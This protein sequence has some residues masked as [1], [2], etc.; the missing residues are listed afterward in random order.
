MARQVRASALLEDAAERSRLGVR[1]RLE[2]LRATAPTVVQAAAAT[3]LAWGVARELVGH[4]TPFF[5]P[6][7]ALIT[8]GLTLGERGRRGLEVAFGVALGIAVADLLVLA[9]GSGTWQ[10]VVV[11]GLAMVVAILLGGSPTLVTQAAASAVLV[12]VLQPPGD[13]LS[14]ARSVDAVVGAGTALLVSFV[15]LPAD[16]LSI[17]RRAAE[18]VLRELAASLD[19]VAAALDLRSADDA[20]A[21]LLRA[22][23]ID[24]YTQAFHVAA[25]DGREAA[26]AL[27]RR[28][29]RGSVAVYAVAAGQLDLAVHNVRVLAR[30][31][32][33]AIER[34]ERIPPTVMAA[35]RELAVAVRALGGAL[36]EPERL[37]GARAPA[38]HAAAVATLALEETANLSASVIVGQVRATAVDLL[39]GTGLSREEALGLVRE[40]VARGRDD[41]T[42]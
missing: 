25:H 32:L 28:G 10:L 20:V 31:A 12:V 5:A 24:V 39:R 6:I 23:G 37:P 27:S 14:F 19:D 42:A 7:A 13:E 1:A 11:T 36:A 21:A 3:G 35:V 34:D 26:L 38:A 18:P 40:A 17:V 22:R 4:P 29:S 41:G 15:V 8:L 9:I 2:R 30:H 16:P 33:A